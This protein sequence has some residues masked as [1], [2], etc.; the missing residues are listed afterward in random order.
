MSSDEGVSE[1]EMQEEVLEDFMG[2]K[3]LSL[4]DYRGM[5]LE[6]D[7]YI[8]PPLAGVPRESTASVYRVTVPLLTKYEKARVLGTRAMQ[9]SRSA[10]PQIIPSAEDDSALKIA[11]KEFEAGKT[12]FI[13]RRFLPDGLYEDWT[14]QELMR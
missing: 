14:L 4:T 6:D 3:T 5:P 10:P 11:Y 1:P 7:E 13:I 12:P 8:E 9:I 2:R